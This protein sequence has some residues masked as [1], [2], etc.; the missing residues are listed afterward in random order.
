MLGGKHDARNIASDALFWRDDERGWR[1]VRVETPSGQPEEAMRAL[2]RFGACGAAVEHLEWRLP[3][4][5]PV[6][7]VFSGGIGA[8]GTVMCDVWGMAM[9]RNAGEDMNGQGSDKAEL[10]VEMAPLH[11]SLAGSI[12]ASL[13]GRVGAVMV[14][15]RGSRMPGL[16][17]VGGCPAGGATVG[18][19][20]VHIGSDMHAQAVDIRVEESR[21]GAQGESAAGDPKPML[22]GHA[23]EA[24]D[25]GTN[26]L[27]LGGGAVCFSFGTVWNEGSYLLVLD[28]DEE[29]KEKTK[30]NTWTEHDVKKPQTNGPSKTQNKSKSITASTTKS[31]PLSQRP[32]T[33]RK[34]TR[35]DSAEHFAQLLA[36]RE[37]VVLQNLDFG[38]CRQRWTIEYLTHKVGAEREVTVH[39]SP[40]ASMSFVD[41]NFNYAKRAFGKFADS[42]G[43]GEHVYL[44]GLSA[45]A[46]ASKPASLADDFPGLAEDFQVPAELKQTVEDRMHSSVLR[47]SGPVRMWLHYD[48][49]ANVLFQ[50]RGDKTLMLYA[51]GD[52][53]SLGI[54]HG[55]SSS[56]LDPF[57]ERTRASSSLRG[58]TP[59]LADLRAGEA[60]MIPPLWA[61][62]AAPA[63]GV[64]VAVNVFFRDLN[65]G[66]A[67]GRDVYGNRDYAAYERGRRDVGRVAEA[68]SGLPDQAA[69]FYLRRLAL[70]LA[71]EAERRGRAAAGQ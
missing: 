44:R 62:A 35:L 45:S 28:D 7:G 42:V 27:V 46:P 14:E 25:D 13:L 63:Q 58:A 38:K 59:W 21:N 69:E 15:S 31:R 39:E 67:V 60:L 56:P 30:R 51:P 48:V 37:P 65:E 22:A 5:S 33:V 6:Q 43:R 4:G 24:V 10:V 29:D 11:I 70:E 1:T 20:V 68:F 41:K 36:A 55:A 32:K 3:S 53:A 9:R 16:C 18:A 12:S 47:V 71:D 54:P 17:I 50:T 57:D 8:Q 2:A 61:H 23:V 26:L 64:S 40:T 19:E 34:I 66:Y 52:A 49:L